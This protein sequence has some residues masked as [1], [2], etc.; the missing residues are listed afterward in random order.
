MAESVRW[1]TKAEAARELEVSIST[2]DRKIGTGEVEVR[3]EGRRV[4]VRMVG[5]YVPAEELLRRAVARERELERSVGEL[6]RKLSQAERR[7]SG[8]ERELDEAKESLSA[9]RQAPLYL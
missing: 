4:Y 5:E 6:E 8:L 2:L 3:R 7:A 9:A 1:V